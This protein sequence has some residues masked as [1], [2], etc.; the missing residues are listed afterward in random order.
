MSA[1]DILPEGPGKDQILGHAHQAVMDA[2]RKGGIA[3]WP[4]TRRLAARS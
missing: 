4:S 3:A 2:A 1:L